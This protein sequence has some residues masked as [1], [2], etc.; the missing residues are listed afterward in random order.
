MKMIPS[1]KNFSSVSAKRTGYSH[2]QSSS[3]R[4]MKQNDFDRI[5]VIF[6]KLKVIVPVATALG[7]YFYYLDSRFS[8][9]DMRNVEYRIQSMKTEDK[10]EA[11]N[12][13]VKIFGEQVIR[14]ETRNDTRE[15]ELRRTIENV[16]GEIRAEKR[17]FS[18]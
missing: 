15:K 18:F 2:Q 11:T 6:E 17:W 8:E 13:N 1:V 9:L 5:M 4:R 12:G 14:A 3:K 16:R 7:G 10:C